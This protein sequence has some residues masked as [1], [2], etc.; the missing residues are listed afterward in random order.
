MSGPVHAIELTKRLIDFDTI[1]PPGNEDGCARFLG[2][3]LEEQGFAVSRHT[4]SAGRTSLV[5]RRS[6]KAPSVAGGKPLCFTGHLDTVPLGAATWSVAPLKGTIVGDRIYGRGSSDMKSGVAA[7]VA[8][9]VACR[10]AADEGPGLTLVL[11]AGEET[12]CEGA[13]H[14]AGQHCVLGDAGAI[15]VGEPTCNEPWVGHKGVLWLNG[16]TEGRTAHGSMPELGINAVYRGA[17]LVTK[18]EDFGFN[19]APHVGLGSPTI[20]VGFLRGGS[21]IN[22]VPDRAEF[23]IDLRTI[24]GMDHQ[25]IK[26]DLMSYLG[27]Q[28][29]SL[30]TA[31]DLAPVWTSPDHPWVSAVRAIAERHNGSATEV[32]GA[33][34]FT[35]ASVL[36]EAFGGAPTI[37]LGPGETKMAHRTDEYCL[38][39]RI[40][41]AVAIYCDII[42]HWQREPGR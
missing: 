24:P 28:L 41:T 11:T 17:R 27:P 37:V 2:N 42:E 35:D 10:A 19:V 33:P 3:L 26:E 23:G 32:R 21:N 40:E 30:D 1:N 25:A 20:S 4:L 8:A 39:E 12:G 34:F 16:E 13:R 14:L 7:M 5:A 18:V 9:A 6:G 36:K 22:S 29:A 31:I 15:V 38:L